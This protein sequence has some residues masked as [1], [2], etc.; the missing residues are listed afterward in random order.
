MESIS[1]YFINSDIIIR[2][3]ISISIASAVLASILMLTI[4][5]LRVRLVFRHK[6]REL[7]KSTWNSV[8]A[9]VALGQD[10]DL[11]KLRR[12]DRYT[13]LFEF[14]DFFSIVR[15][16]SIT[17]L[18]L[19]ARK[20]RLNEHAHHMINGKSLHNRLVG[21]YT[22]G[23]MREY[24]SWN[25]LMALVHNKISIL[26]ITAVRSLLLI[27]PKQGVRVVL[28]LLI[29][30]HQWP[31]PSVAYSM[32]L[33]GPNNVCA[34]L[35]EM[36]RHVAPD[37]QIRLLRYMD[38]INCDIIYDGVTKIL[39]STD[40]PHVISVCLDIVHDIRAL[41]IVRLYTNHPKWYIRMHAARAIGKIG[42]MQDIPRLLEMLKDPAWWVR[43]RS[44]Q[45]IAA[46]VSYNRDTIRQLI[47]QVDDAY[48]QDILTQVI[49]EIRDN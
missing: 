40:D 5:F 47:E 49:A 9:R 8:L 39:K 20:L 45:A 12:A 36:S 38:T 25:D 27:D 48:G 34:P 6:R 23:H 22:L 30:E 21:I 33:A 28:P 24:S 44:A 26:A 11:P 17:N 41:D 43:Y 1:A 18:K 4:I 3:A 19:L 46:L 15:G 37:C 10:T 2:V 13:F 14:N 16:D 35:A 42:N 29:T 32:K 31:W 7:V